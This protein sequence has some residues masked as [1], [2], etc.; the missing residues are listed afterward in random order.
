M[1]TTCQTC[2]APIAP[3]PAH[4]RNDDWMCCDECAAEEYAYQEQMEAIRQEDE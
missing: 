3:H 1:I 4:W 2:G